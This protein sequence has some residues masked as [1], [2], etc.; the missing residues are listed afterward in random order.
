MRSCCCCATPASRF[1][2]RRHWSGELILRRAKS[3]ELVTVLLPNEALAALKAIERPARQHYFWTG[4]SGP[5]TDGKYRR[6]RLK[7]VASDAGMDGFHPHRLRDRFAVE[8]LISDMCIDDVSRL[9]RHSS[10]CTTE[11]YYASWNRARRRRL[12]RLVREVHR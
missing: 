6:S 10:A 1:R 7:L 3:G 12:A 9:R 5:V 2:T 11:K 4:E 8:L